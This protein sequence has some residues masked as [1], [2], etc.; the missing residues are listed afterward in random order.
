MSHLKEI[1][2]AYLAC[3]NAQ[4][5]KLLPEYVSEQVV[6]NDRYLGISGYVEMLKGNYHDIPDLRFESKLIVSDGDF[7]AAR[8]YF[9][10]TPKGEF[11]N[12]AI[13][14]RKVK[15]SENVIY[16]FRDEM[17]VQ[18]WSVVDKAAIEIQLLM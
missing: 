5:W 6:H 2:E 14:G 8:L 7:V 9:D 17:I 4:D 18:I 16:Q 3:L 13:N 11:L 10:C 12:L 15:F 1:Y